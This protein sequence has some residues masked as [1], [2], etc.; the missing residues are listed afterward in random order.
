MSRRP[1]V[2]VVVSL[3]LVALGLLLPYMQRNR[4]NAALVASRNN[5]RELSLFASHHVNP[6]PGLD[7]TR[8]VAEVPAA[9]ILQ[10]GVPPEERLSWVVSVLPALD[11][12][13]NPTELLISQI[14]R[15]QPWAAEPNQQ[16]ARSQLA[17]LVCPSNPPQRLPDSPAPTSYVGIGGVGTDAATLPL[18]PTVPPPPRAGAFRYDAPTPFDRIADGFSQTLLMGET[19]DSPGP[20]LR[21]G[22]S[23]TRVFDT[24]SGAKPLL[25]VGGQFGGFF[26]G[27][28]NFAMCDGSVRP[29]TTQTTPDLL[30]RLATIAGTEDVRPPE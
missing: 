13:R 26:P 18:L 16:A 30:L 17:V 23:T 29:F 3:V 2:V 24:A 22:A 15:D 9:T 19:A 4:M 27:V 5:L 6:I 12:K 25:G 20:W 14:K 11:Q 1:A 21:G 8:I 7:P 10:Q 28:S